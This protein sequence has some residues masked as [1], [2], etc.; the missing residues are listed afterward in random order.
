MDV[1]WIDARLAKVGRPVRSLEDDQVW[2][3]REV[4]GSHEVADLQQQYNT[5]RQFV[6]VL[7]RGGH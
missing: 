1:C 6:E 3:V 5:W 2:M 4:Y 7:D